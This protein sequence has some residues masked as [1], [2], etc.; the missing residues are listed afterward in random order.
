M[1]KNDIRN[2]FLELRKK[3]FDPLLNISFNLIKKFIPNNKNNP[4]IGGYYPVSHEMDC[5]NVRRETRGQQI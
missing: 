3:K 4:I 5:L 1:N 2:K